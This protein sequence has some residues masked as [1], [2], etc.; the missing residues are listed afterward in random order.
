MES[1]EIVTLLKDALSM[2][3]EVFENLANSSFVPPG[4]DFSSV[5]N[6]GLSLMDQATT[7]ANLALISFLKGTLELS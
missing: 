7:T 1:S 6:F 2:R 5:D 3:F 4:F